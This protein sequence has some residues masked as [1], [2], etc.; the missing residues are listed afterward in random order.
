[1]I[2]NPDASKAKKSAKGMNNVTPRT[3]AIRPSQ[4]YPAAEV[5][6][7][8]AA[9]SMKTPRAEFQSTQLS[10]RSR[11]SAWSAGAETFVGLSASARFAA[12]TKPSALANMTPPPT[13][14][15]SE[16]DVPSSERSDRASHEANRTAVN[17]ANPK[18]NETTN[19]RA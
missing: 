10:L 13:R 1:M 3:S 5:R 7:A 4:R 18:T 17:A 9:P 11:L 8:P 12:P 2:H 16:T 15:R 19:R 14:T 6:H